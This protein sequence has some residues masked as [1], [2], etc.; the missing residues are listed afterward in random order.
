ML[1]LLTQ[2]GLV[3]VYVASTVLFLVLAYIHVQMRE[4]EEQGRTFERNLVK[5]V[6]GFDNIKHF[7]NVIL[8]IYLSHT[9]NS[10]HK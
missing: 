7:L 3:T 4:K 8:N 1:P 9:S 10:R 2:D 6:V 5:F